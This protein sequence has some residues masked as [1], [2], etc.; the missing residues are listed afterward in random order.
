[1]KLGFRT[2]ERRGDFFYI[3]GKP[4]RML[5]AN[6]TPMSIRPNDAVLADTFLRKM[7]DGGLF[8]TRTTTAPFN[9]TWLQAA[10]RQGVAVS[11]EGAFPWLM[12]RGDIPDSNLLRLWREE[13]FD[14]VRSARNHPSVLLWT[15]NNEMK[16]YEKD[17]VRARVQAKFRIVSD[18]VKSLR[19]LDPTRPVVFDS[20][21]R[22]DTAKF[23]RKFMAGI[24]D[25]DADDIH[26][27]FNWYYFSIFD[28]FDSTFTRW[29]K[30]PGRPLISQEF[31]SGYPTNDAGHPT[32]FYTYPHYVPQALVGQWAYEDHDPRYFLERQAF[33]AKEGFEGLRRSTTSLAGL[34]AFSSICW[35]RD[36][37]DAARISPYPTYEAMKLAAQTVLVSAE[38]WSRHFYAGDTLRARVCVVN[39]GSD[40]RDLPASKLRWRID[41]QGVSLA[42]GEQAVP[43]VAH[44]SRHWDSLA[45]RLAAPQ[46]PEGGVYGA[47]QLP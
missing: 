26:S 29:Y 19:Q 11:F 16:F 27:Y 30:N 44:F 37:Y 13:F 45:I 17:T 2:F 38:L 20:G 33:I 5:G 23:D 46:P 14:L 36:V 18:V 22:R 10:D 42:S 32:R 3:N 34:Q 35:F 15:V 9:E 31:S 21:Y 12:M 8:F 43:S 6:H 39:D 24:D 25:G 7:H 28:C 1:M 40:G 4:R 41:Y 47:G